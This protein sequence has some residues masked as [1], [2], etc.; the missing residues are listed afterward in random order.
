MDIIFENGEKTQLINWNDFDCKGTNYFRIVNLNLFKK[1]NIIAVKYT[2]KRTYHTMI[3]KKN[4]GELSSYVK[5][6]LL[7][8]DNINNA[9]TTIPLCEED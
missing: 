9:T 4:I 1:S 8:L 5:N 7:E 6:V 3:I 2:N